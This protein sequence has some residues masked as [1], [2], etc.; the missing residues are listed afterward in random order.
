MIDSYNT[1]YRSDRNSNDGEI[2]LY[3]REDIPSYLIATG[4]EPMESFWVELNLRDE[5]Y[6]I[7]YSYN[8]QKTAINNHLAT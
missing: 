8:L 3:I 1:P 4:K 2:L 5:K 7:N 6:L